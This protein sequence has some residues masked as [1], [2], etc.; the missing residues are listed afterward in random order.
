[1]KHIH[2]PDSVSEYQEAFVAEALPDSR[3]PGDDFYR[4]LIG[5]VLDQKTPLLYEQTHPDEYAN[6]S[7]NHH[8]LLRRD[9]SQTTLGAAA[10]VMSLYAL[11][12]LTHMTNWLPT[13]L[14]EISAQEYADQFT[15]SEYRASNES[16]ILVHYRVPELRGDVFPE[17]TIAVDVLKRMGIER[18]DSSLIGK[19]RAL[20]VEHDQFDE[21]I[22][23]D[24]EAK[25]ALARLKQFNGNRE[26][27][28]KHYAEIRHLFTDSLFP[29]GTGLTDTEYEQAIAAYEPQSDQAKYEANVITNVRLGFAMCGMKVP[30]L[31]SFS[32][33]K[34]AVK[35][36]EG[37]HALVRN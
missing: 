5:W 3:I 6:L 28:V 8:W 9:Y 36:L 32:D 25:Q 12:E 11:H 19:L 14:D 22:G 34:A 1:M 37:Q 17:T 31:A 4:R 20:I 35:E 24:D 7:I 26:W 21:L 2:I 10:T 16:E 13:R 29:L 30:L 18:P 15:R 23:Q 27:A 33:A